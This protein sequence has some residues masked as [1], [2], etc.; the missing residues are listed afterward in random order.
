MYLAFEVMNLTY[1]KAVD[2]KKVLDGVL[3]ADKVNIDER[4][5]KVI[6][7]GTPDER[8]LAAQIIQSLDVEM[9][10]LSPKPA[11]L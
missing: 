6:I 9:A 5:N 3:G 2:A 1:A 8:A 7:L 10:S 11:V 4:T